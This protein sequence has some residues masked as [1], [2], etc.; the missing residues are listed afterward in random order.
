ML[1]LDELLASASFTEAV[2]NL[3]AD[4]RKAHGLPGVDQLGLVVPDVEKAARRLE[5]LGIGPFLIT[6]GS[7]AR[8]DE[9]GEPGKFRGKLGLARHHGVDLELLEPGEGS[10][11]YRRSL[12]PGGGIVVQHLGFFVKNVDEKMAEL[13]RA[14]H[15][16]WV[17]GRINAWPCRFEFAYMDTEKTAETIIELLNFSLMGIRFKPFGSAYHFLGKLEQVIGVRCI[18]VG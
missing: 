13:N 10:D 4:F 3:A 9:R 1:L 16:T 11:F 15:S 2:D 18:D 7:L 5:T 14:G 17:R 8:W 12:D 6:S